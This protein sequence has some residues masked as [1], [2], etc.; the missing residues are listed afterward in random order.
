MISNDAMLTAIFAK[1]IEDELNKKK[2]GLPI[3]FEIEAYSNRLV[4]YY[5]SRVLEIDTY[6]KVCT[7][8]ID[9]EKFHVSLDD[10]DKNSEVVFKWFNAVIA[11]VTDTAKIFNYI[12]DQQDRKNDRIAEAI[13]KE[14]AYTDGD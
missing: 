7:Y 6:C 13:E 3:N 8:D 1:K 10:V 9:N 4:I 2:E 12:R 11:L 5:V 14:K